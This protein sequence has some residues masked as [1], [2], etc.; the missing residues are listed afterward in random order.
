MTFMTTGLLSDSVCH[1]GDWEGVWLWARPLPASRSPD[2]A[3]DR[4]PDEEA[5]KLFFSPLMAG[6]LLFARD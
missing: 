5:G 2:G 4:T 3:D 6:V 1:A